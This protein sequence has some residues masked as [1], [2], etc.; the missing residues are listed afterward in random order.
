VTRLIHS[1]FLLQKTLF[2]HKSRKVSSYIHTLCHTYFCSTCHKVISTKTGDNY[3]SYFMLL[4]IY[5]SITLC[6][7]SKQSIVCLSV[8]LLVCLFV[9]WHWNGCLIWYYCVKHCQRQITSGSPKQHCL[10][11]QAAFSLFEGG[12]VE[13]LTVMCIYSTK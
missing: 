2:R 13:I 9:C 6:N 10:F 4:N 5:A 7:L 3:Y 8:Y 12:N 11:H 1:C